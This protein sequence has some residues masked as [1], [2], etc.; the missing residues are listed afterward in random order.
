MRVMDEKVS[1]QINGRMHQFQSK[2]S[3]LNDL[4]GL[5]PA[6]LDQVKHLAKHLNDMMRSKA[7]ACDIFELR[8]S[9]TNKQDTEQC[10][11]AIDAIHKM[12]ENIA[13]M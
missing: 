5:G 3:K 13:F 11:R 8:E 10:M 9:K 1:S 4:A 12:M 6:A 7:E 2:M